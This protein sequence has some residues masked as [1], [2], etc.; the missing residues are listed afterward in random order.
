MSAELGVWFTIGGILGA[1]VTSVTGSTVKHLDRVRKATASTERTSGRVAGYRAMRQTLGAATAA[2]RGAER[3]AADLHRQL[4]S[5]RGPTDA[6][7]KQWRAARAESLRL[8]EPPGSSARR[9]SASSARSRSPAW[10]CGGW[11]PRSGV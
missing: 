9:W 7:R 8:G 11:T 10:T 1:S 4:A 6:L 3:R 5:G 2:L